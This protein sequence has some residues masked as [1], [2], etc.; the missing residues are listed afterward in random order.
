MLRD[1]K[2]QVHAAHQ[3]LMT[4]G[5][6]CGGLGSVSVIDREAGQVVVTPDGLAGEA[7]ATGSMVIVSLETAEI[8]DGG[9]PPSQDTPAHL[10]LYRAFENIGAIVHARSLHA[11][12]WAQVRRNI[13][14]FGTT[15]AACFVGP[16]PC[17]RPL[18]EADL[19]GDCAR[20]IGKAIVEQFRS[21][22]VDPLRMPVCL[23]GNHG[24]FAWGASV[25]L[26]VETVARLELVARLAGETLKLDADPRPLPRGLSARYFDTYGRRDAHPAE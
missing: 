25:E 1:L 22:Q 24:P 5:L 9:A 11:T 3:R 19:D 12:A 10:E 8:L 18:G 13:P 26:A 23:V 4:E 20:A 17:T 14:V 15:H 6:D 16:V 2:K 7:V 21:E